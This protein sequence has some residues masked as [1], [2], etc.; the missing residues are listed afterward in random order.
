HAHS[1]EFERQVWHGVVAPPLA[2]ISENGACKLSRE[3]IYRKSAW[4]CQCTIHE[5]IHV[6]VVI[7]GTDRSRNTKLD[8]DGSVGQN[9][10]AY[11]IQGMCSLDKCQVG[12]VSSGSPLHKM[13]VL[14]GYGNAEGLAM[15]A[16]VRAY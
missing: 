12:D 6:K 2:A 14:A 3:C 1:C 9:R 7:T 16:V 15:E 8:I 4:K 13:G 10:T 11:H 5:T